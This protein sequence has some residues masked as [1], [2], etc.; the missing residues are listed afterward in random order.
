M[1]ADFPTCSRPL[2]EADP[3]GLLHAAGQRRRARAAHGEAIQD[4][5][6]YRPFTGILPSEEDRI[7]PRLPRREAPR[8]TPVPD[9]PW[10]ERLGRRS[11]TTP[12]GTSI[13]MKGGG[14]TAGP[15]PVP[16]ALARGWAMAG[17][18]ILVVE[19]ER[20]VARGLVY[21]LREDGFEVMH[22]ET[23][24]EALE[25]ARAW[26]PHLLLLDLRLPDTSGR[27]VCRTLRADGSRVPII[28]VTALDDELDRVLGLELGADDYVVKPYSLRELLSRVRALLRRAYGDL[29]PGDAPRA[30][31][32]GPLRLDL[33]RFT[34]TI[35]GRPVDLTPTEFKL[36]RHL[37]AHPGRPF[38]RSQL[39]EAVWGYDDS[40]GSDR[41]VDVHIR[42]LRAKLERDPSRPALIVT[43]RGV[44][45]KLEP[46][47][48]P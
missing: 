6:G 47:A 25:A 40:L 42:H 43:V 37:A 27:D 8:A 11:G 5:G 44:G 36:L 22:A 23:G 10:P 41:T 38:D 9:D 26:R 48:R 13:L 28:M 20:A 46:T 16:R 33:E 45:Y 15:R 35:D 17:E 30:L 2:A 4:H 1:W 7:L 29:A 32:A 21:A 12:H 31:E 18:R 14:P 24:A 34:A 19:D 39:I 3:I